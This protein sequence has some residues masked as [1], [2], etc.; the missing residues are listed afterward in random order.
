MKTSK[1]LLIELSIIIFWYCTWNLLDYFFQINEKNYIL[2][3][4]VGLSSLYIMY[5][6]RR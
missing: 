4:I 3:M 5:K 2:F 6:C 1:F